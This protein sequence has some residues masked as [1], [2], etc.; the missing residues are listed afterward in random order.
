MF[1]ARLFPM[2]QQ[3]MR[4]SIALFACFLLSGEVGAKPVEEER[5]AAFA[6][7]SVLFTVKPEIASSPFFSSEWL[8]DNGSGG[9]PEGFTDEHPRIDKWETEPQD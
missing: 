4:S 9:F 5:F 1:A 3:V 6:Q 2:I 7:P 8:A